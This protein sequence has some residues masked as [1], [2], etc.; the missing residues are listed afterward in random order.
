MGRAFGVV[1]VVLV[2]V[3]ASVVLPTVRDVSLADSRP[4]QASADGADPAAEVDG[5]TTLLDLTARLGQPAEPEFGQPVDAADPAAPNLVT[6][7]TTVE[8]EPEPC[9]AG[10]QGRLELINQV[11][12]APEAE[13]SSLQNPD[14]RRRYRHAV[15]DTMYCAVLQRTADQDGL[16]YWSDAL[17][18]GLTAWNL[19]RELTASEEHQAVAAELGTAHAADLAEAR[20]VALALDAKV[21]PDGLRI[22]IP[23]SA[24][25]FDRQ[26]AD[27]GLD[28]PDYVTEALVH[29]TRHRPSQRVNVAYVHLSRSR[30]V[31]VSP[32]SNRR[33]TV[34]SWA[35]EIGAHVAVNANWF[36]PWDGPAVS[37]G[38]S[39][40]GAD[41]SYTSLFGF[42]EFGDSIIEHHRVVN[43]GV[44][45]RIT[46]GVSGHP[47][48]V[49]RGE[50]TDDFGTDPTFL[51]RHPRTAIGL[52]ESGDVLI[53]VTV[54]GRS[55][56]AA[57]MTGAE[58]VDLLV[59]L[60]AHE[61]VMLDGGGSSAMWLAGR[62]VV[63]RPAGGLR[64]VGNQIAVFGN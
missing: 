8:E 50:P 30:G 19:Y 64:L 10:E 2:I 42:T 34:G 55:S 20:R 62:G 49:H 48:L 21:W 46:E 51:R 31:S 58:T 39:Y 40:A 6:S 59:A 7:S 14:F 41:H 63:N 57:G 27:A 17:A 45:P 56:S 25:E 26:V 13:L 44:D 60:G 29:G 52:D 32:G 16:I 43:D 1:V 24:D 15:V 54:D 18:Q 35:E 4:A 53:L 38:V 33:A 36:A 22:R 23:I 61:A 12:D 5:P 9:L 28:N 11:V 47:T 3:T 37:G